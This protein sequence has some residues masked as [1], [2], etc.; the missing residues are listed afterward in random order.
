MNHQL[1]ESPKDYLAAGPL[2]KEFTDIKRDIQLAGDAV[3][4]EL[5]QQLAKWDH[6]V[7]DAAYLDSLVISNMD[8]VLNEIRFSRYG[9][10][11]LITNEDVMPEHQIE[12]INRILSAHGFHYISETEHGEPFRRRDRINGDWFHRYFDYI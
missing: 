4:N 5:P 10:M 6:S 7:Q 11:A 3:I 1:F 9:K 8:N 12:V 2:S